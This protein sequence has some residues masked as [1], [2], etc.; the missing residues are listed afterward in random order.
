LEKIVKMNLS[1]EEEQKNSTLISLNQQWEQQQR[2][3]S[4]NAI[5]NL[6]KSLENENRDILNEFK[7]KQFGQTQ[8]INFQSSSHIDD[9][10]QEVSHT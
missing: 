3:L 7:I 8:K 9:S 5:K 6:D 1:D 4:K 10:I 2:D